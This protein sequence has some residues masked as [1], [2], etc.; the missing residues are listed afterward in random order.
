ML[1]KILLVSFTLSLPLLF[2]YI[3]EPHI[4]EEQI[5]SQHKQ[6]VKVVF[7]QQENCFRRQDNMKQKLVPFLPENMTAWDRPKDRQVFLFRGYSYST[8]RTNLLNSEKE[9]ADSD[10]FDVTRW[11][12]EDE[13]QSVEDTTSNHDPERFVLRQ[14][15]T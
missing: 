1:A 5:R 2:F 13:K 14:C 3:F 6:T 9:T 8:V 11:H 10:R 7:E 12:S 15:D 4:V